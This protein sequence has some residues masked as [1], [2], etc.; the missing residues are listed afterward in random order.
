MSNRFFKIN[1]SIFF[2]T[3]VLM[4]LFIVVTLW[5]GEPMEDFFK[6]FKEWVTS[7]FGW[8]FI[9]CVNI[10][11]VFCIYLAASKY[12]SIKLGGLDSKPE[13]SRIAW[14]SML[15]SAGTGI[16]LLFWGVAEPVIHYSSPPYGEGYTQD[17]A[18]LAMSYSFMH[19]GFH[20]WGIYAIVA[21]SLGF[22]AYNRKL[23]LTIRSVFYPLLGD[24]INGWIGYTIDVFAG[25]AT[26]FGL[27]TSL[28]LGVNQIGAG[29][30]ILTDIENTLLVQMILII[31]I[32][33]IASFSV[34]AGVDKGVRRL[35]EWNIRLA[36]LLLVLLIVLGP[37]LFIF[38]STIQ[39]IG[40]YMSSIVQQ[41]TWTSAFMEEDW[42]GDWTVFYWAWWISWSPFVGMFIA[43]ISKGRTIRE[44]VLGGLLV[45]GLLTFVWLSA[46]GG[47]AIFMDLQKAGNELAKEISG[48]EAT[49]LFIFLNEFPYAAV[50]SV[51]ALILIAVFFITSSDSGSLVIAS[52]SAGG[53]RD[54]PTV[55]RIFWA[56]AE[57]AVAAVLLIGGGL[58]ALQTATI[59]TGL[60]FL[61]ILL[62]MT[63]S[64]REGL[65]KEYSRLQQEESKETKAN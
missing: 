55:Q 52:I 7:T 32:T 23:P 36:A 10:F 34:Y 35:S 19:W 37:T 59:T 4:V 11:I 26:L 39:N 6:Q 25:L 13:F 29:I 3:T 42:Q 43:R 47:S 31:V 12:G 2:P 27:A 33:I 22:F 16:G 63:Y 62:V 65:Q 58:T 64:L 48:D 30:E 28:G 9:L 15:F 14:F 61:I 44:F 20:A 40:V 17:A 5:V 1:S 57:G 24:K 60:P 8:F 49:A 45:P 51:I 50:L 46:T 38:K 41:A 56:N 54:V 18:A 21:L 53:D